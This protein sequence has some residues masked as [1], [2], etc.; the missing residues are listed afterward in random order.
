MNTTT[1]REIFV[2]SQSANIFVRTAGNPEADNV[3]ISLHG[4]PGLSHRYLRDL[5]RLAGADF[6]IVGYDQRACGQSS[7]SDQPENDFTPN[8]FVQ[9]LEAVR[10]AVA[11]QKKVHLFGHSWGGYVAMAYAIAHPEHVR[12]L[13]FVDSVPP[14]LTGRQAGVQR[15]MQRIQELQQQGKIIKDAE[16]LEDKLEFLK[17]IFVVYFYNHELRRNIPDDIFD[18]NAEAEPKTWSAVGNYDMREQ[19]AGL[20]MLVLIVYGANDPFGIPWAEETR[21]AFSQVKPTMEIIQQCGH[22]PWVEQPET[23][24]RSLGDFLHANG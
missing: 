12:S 24:Y 7:Y 2:P 16:K 17:Q 6:L 23:F 10:Q 18:M 14:T 21:D 13:I 20:T 8:A 9:D 5:E 1:I 15:I 11:G 4:G 3:L 22:L 19:L